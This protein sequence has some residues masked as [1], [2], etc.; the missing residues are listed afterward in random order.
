[1]NLGLHQP[2]VSVIWDLAPHDLSILSYWLGTMPTEITAMTR[3]CVLPNTPDVAFLNMRYESGTIAHL[4]LAWLSPV[5]LRRTSLVGS[6]KMIVYEDGTLSIDFEKIGFSKWSISIDY[7][8]IISC[9]NN[10]GETLDIR[11]KRIADNIR[12][13][14]LK[15]YT[16]D[17]QQFLL[18]TFQRY[19]G[20]YLAAVEF[21]KQMPLNNQAPAE[22]AAS[23][24]KPSD[25]TDL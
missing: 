23:D 24:I 18:E 5:K 11:Y 6:E 21:R 2:D 12:S 10:N 4:E 13:I 17:Q 16:K 22:I 19:Y 8:E 9:T 25:Q 14:D 20:R 15:K 7:K 3:S 1:M